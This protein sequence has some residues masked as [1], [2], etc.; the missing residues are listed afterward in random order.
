MPDLLKLMTSF[1]ILLINVIPSFQDDFIFP[2]TVSQSP[3]LLLSPHEGLQSCPAWSM[4]LHGQAGLL[5]ASHWS[6]GVLRP[7]SAQTARALAPWPSHPGGKNLLLTSSLSISPSFFH[8]SHPPTMY[9][10]QNPAVSPLSPVAG[11]GISA[12]SP[13]PPHSTPEVSHSLPVAPG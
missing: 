10:V 9:P 2:F 12:G 3:V 4:T 1:F 13:E 6:N 7:K 8:S 5:R 11:A